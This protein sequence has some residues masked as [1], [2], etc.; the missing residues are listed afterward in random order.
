MAGPDDD[1]AFAAT[2]APAPSVV[3]N[4]AP[5]RRPRRI[6]SHRRSRRTRRRPRS[7]RSCSGRAMGAKPAA[8]VPAARERAEL[9]RDDGRAGDGRAAAAA[10][11]RASLYETARSRAAAWAASSPP[12]IAGSAARSRSR[13]C[14]IRSTT[15]SARFQREALI[16][17]RLQHPGIVPVYEA[18]RWPTGEPFFAM[19]LVLGPAAR[20]G[21]RGG[22]RRSQERLALL[23]RVAAA[24]DAIAYAHSQRDHPPRPQARRTC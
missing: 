12:R 2:V 7:R 15:R 23:P 3:P 5:K 14:S 6:R 1:D 13:S 17:A 22:A 16:T 18:G 8:V 10:R 9:R 19:K 4:A 20:P 21:D 11:G 24:C